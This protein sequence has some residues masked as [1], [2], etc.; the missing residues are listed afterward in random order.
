MSFI[1]SASGALRKLAW[2][3]VRIAASV[4]TAIAA[5]I[6]EPGAH[7]WRFIATY[8]LNGD[9]ARRMQSSIALRR[10]DAPGLRMHGDQIRIGTAGAVIDLRDSTVTEGL[11]NGII[12]QYL[13]VWYPCITRHPIPF[14]TGEGPYQS[15]QCTIRHGDVVIDAGANFGIFTWYAAEQVGDA[16]TVLAFEPSSSCVNL[17][18]RSVRSSTIGHRVRVV[19]K[20][21]A[22]R[23]SV[24]HFTTEDLSAGNVPVAG[25]PSRPSEKVE[26]IWLAG[27]PSTSGRVRPPA[28]VYASRPMISITISWSP[29]RRGRAKPSFW[30]TS[31]AGSS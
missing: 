15:G 24:T 20:G 9:I 14:F 30:S 5:V 19:Q 13:D 23:A 22:A 6:T 25:D 8:L 4:P 2:R 16:G 21:L 26:L 12:M 17:L 28:G 1:D 10:G 27:A 11:L 31:A 3:L 18:Q 7:P 29:V